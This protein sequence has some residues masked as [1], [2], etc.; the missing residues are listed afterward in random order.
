MSLMTKIFVYI[1]SLE[2]LIKY[3]T[4][5][6]YNSV[7]PS[8]S[9]VGRR[10]RISEPWNL[11]YLTKNA[12]RYGISIIIE[13]LASDIK[14]KNGGFFQTWAGDCTSYIYL[15]RGRCQ[16]EEMASDCGTTP[17]CAVPLQRRY[18]W[19]ADPINWWSSG[20]ELRCCSPF[21]TKYLHPASD[22]NP[23]LSTRLCSVVPSWSSTSHLHWTWLEFIRRF[24]LPDGS[25]ETRSCNFARAP[26]FFQLK[27]L[28]LYS[29]EEKERLPI[30][31]PPPQS[32]HSAESRHARLALGAQA[33]LNAWVLKLTRLRLAVRVF[34]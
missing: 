13:K 6:N 34:R 2:K 12:I 31:P 1:A 23:L 32:S 15:W 24:L 27:P 20:R 29:T 18:R 21:S 5:F 11:G 10:S 9:E 28:R 26:H 4:P 7:N 8:G 19:C 30:P 16:G 3:K 33:N 22:R 25:N 14:W 17:T